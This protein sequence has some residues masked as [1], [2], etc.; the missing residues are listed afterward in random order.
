MP[1][2]RTKYE[3]TRPHSAARHDWFV[4]GARGA[5]HLWITESPPGDLRHTYSAGLE[6]HYR[7][8]PNYM[9]D[10]APSQ[11][12][13]WVLKCP[14]WHDGSS[15]YAV[16]RYLPIWKADPHNHD[17]MFQI[18]QQEYDAQFSRVCEPL[19]T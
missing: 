1:Q 8:P 4:I 7:S 18:L 6:M 19:K 9:A 5:V 10:M 11:D 12:Q 13:C 14:C 3:Y 17:K 2:F 16:E 15:L